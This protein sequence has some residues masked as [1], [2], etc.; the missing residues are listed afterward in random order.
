[1]RK[2]NVIQLDFEKENLCELKKWRNIFF[3]VKFF[4]FFMTML[5]LYGTIQTKSIINGIGLG[6]C[7]TS[8]I[9]LLTYKDSINIWITNS[10][11]KI[12]GL[13]EILEIIKNDSKQNSSVGRV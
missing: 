2:Y 6:I 4:N 12:K 7:S 3:L 10:K 9:F 11:D 13:D 1:M 8:F 5:N